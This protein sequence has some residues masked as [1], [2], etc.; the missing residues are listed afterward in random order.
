MVFAP[1]TKRDAADANKWESDEVTRLAFNC[2]EETE[3]DEA[4]T[5]YYADGTDW[6]APSKIY[7]MPMVPVVSDTALSAAPQFICA[8][9]PK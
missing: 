9:K 2:R 8:W 3:G 5:I 7:P 6:I 1:Q 4:L